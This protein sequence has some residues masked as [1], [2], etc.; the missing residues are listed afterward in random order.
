VLSTRFVPPSRAGYEGYSGSPFVRWQSCATPEAL[1]AMIS[2]PK[3]GKI[4]MGAMYTTAPNLRYK[5]QNPM[6]ADGREFVV[7]ID[8][9]DYPGGSNDLE[10]CDRMWPLVAVGLEVALRVLTT[11]FGFQHVLRVYSGRRGGHLWVCDKRAC[12]L[13]DDARDAIVKWM[14]P[15]AKQGRTSWHYLAN[16]P[17]FDVISDELMVPFFRDVAIKPIEHGGLGMF[18]IAFQRRAFVLAMDLKDT[19]S[20]VVEVEQVDTPGRAFAIIELFCKH[21]AV[22]RLRMVATIWD[23]IGPR[24]DASVSKHANHTLKIPFSV[25]PKTL[26]LSVPIEHGSIFN[27]PVAK[28]APTVMALFGPDSKAARRVLAITIHGFSLFVERLS[29]STTEQWK[30]PVLSL[31]SFKRQKVHDMRGNMPLQTVRVPDRL[32]P[33]APFVRCVW[34]LDRSFTVHA[35]NHTPTQV[36]I[37][38]TSTERARRVVA[39][40]AYL[41]FPP[42]TYRTLDKYTDNLLQMVEHARRNPGCAWHCFSKCYIVVVSTNGEFDS[43]STT[44]M[45]RLA[46]RLCVPQEVCV[47]NTTWGTSGILSYLKQKLGPL[48]E[49]VCS[50]N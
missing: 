21:S 45:D 10:D 33:T 39:S 16:H 19:R 2:K 49:D 9:T 50:L 47:A 38:M 26:R 27:F 29:K 43:R 1:L 14:S 23:L 30:P 37:F 40:G 36:Q 46:E 11:H 25:H 22:G 6:Q 24:L 34:I 4:N 41:P 7:D 31:P 17:N 48:L 44:R 12:S 32:A 13:S 20:L 18:E 35:L 42:E 28:R 5:Q 3:V 15:H 8:L